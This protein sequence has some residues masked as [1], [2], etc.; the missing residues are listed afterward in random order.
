MDARVFVSGNPTITMSS[1]SV[2]PLLVTYGTYPIRR[3]LIKPFVGVMGTG[4]SLLLTKD[5]PEP[6]MSSNAPLEG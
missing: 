3:G 4:G 6:T 1:L 5:F 2:P